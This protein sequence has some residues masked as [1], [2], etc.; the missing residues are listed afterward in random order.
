VQEEK[1]GGVFGGMRFA[2]SCC[3]G[4]IPNLRRE[5]GCGRGT[6]MEMEMEMDPRAPVWYAMHAVETGDV[7]R[8]DGWYEEG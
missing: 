2:R 5:L 4:V 3:V 8:K 7:L 6:E 1:V